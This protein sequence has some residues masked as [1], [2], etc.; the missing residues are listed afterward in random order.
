[1][2]KFKLTKIHV[3][4][5][6]QSLVNEKCKWCFSGNKWLKC[7]YYK[8]N[9]PLLCVSKIFLKT[10]FIGVMYYL[11]IRIKKVPKTHGVLQYTLT[12]DKTFRKQNKIIPLFC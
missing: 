10:A 9:M 6:F 11:K 8:E 4:S 7:T 3:T 12:F 5:I 2:F 1:M